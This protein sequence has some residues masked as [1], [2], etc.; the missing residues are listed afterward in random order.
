MA[1]KQP[2]LEFSGPCRVM[3]SIKIYLMLVVIIIVLASLQAIIPLAINQGQ[4]MSWLTVIIV[5]I[6]GGLVWYCHPKRGFLHYGLLIFPLNNVFGI[7]F[8]VEAVWASLWS[9]LT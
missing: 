3:T 8:L 6:L 7:L 4:Q 1:P 2:W 9:F 5:T